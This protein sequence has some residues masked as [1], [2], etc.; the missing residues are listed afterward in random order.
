MFWSKLGLCKR[1]E[2]PLNQSGTSL[3]AFNIKKVAEQL[4][5]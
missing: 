4:L 3:L 1:D 2:L 5:S